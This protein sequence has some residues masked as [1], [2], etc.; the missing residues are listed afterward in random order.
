MSVVFVQGTGAQSSGSVASLSIGFSANVTTGNAIAVGMINNADKCLQNSVTD[1]LGNTYKQVIYQNGANASAA[2]SAG[3]YANNIIGGSCTI[4]LDPNGSDFVSGCIAEFSGVDNDLALDGYGGVTNSASSTLTTS[5]FDMGRDGVI[6]S[7][8]E[9]NGTST[10]LDPGGGA[11]QIAE[12]ENATNAMPFNGAYLMVTAGTGKNATFTM[13]ATKNSTAIA[14][15][16]RA[17][18][19]SG[20]SLRYSP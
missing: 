8:M 16:L 15:G 19:V 2:F 3:F 10:T 1:T 11:T 7:I 14:F 17:A 4:T 18:L 9:Q 6:F 5:K 20:A 12:N 13:G